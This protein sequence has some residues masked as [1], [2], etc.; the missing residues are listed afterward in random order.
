MKKSEG[1]LLREYARIIAEASVEDATGFSSDVDLP[2]E[3][4]MDNDEVGYNKEGG[5]MRDAINMNAASNDPVDELSR[6]IGSIIRSDPKEINRAI[7][8]FLNENNLE[9]TPIGGV[10]NSEG[11]V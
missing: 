1:E 3:S 6:H 4:M 7:E 9:I 5:P 2:D 10:S 8:E 11:Q